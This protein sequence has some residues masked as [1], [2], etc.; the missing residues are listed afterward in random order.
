MLKE[1]READ[2]LEDDDKWFLCRPEESFGLWKLCESFEWRFLPFPGSL[3]EQPEWFLKDMATLNWLNRI[4][5]RD[6]GMK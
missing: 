2:S 4:V 5:R 6:L 1:Y 3:V